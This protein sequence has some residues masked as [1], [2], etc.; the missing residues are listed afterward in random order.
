MSDLSRTYLELITSYHLVK[1]CDTFL[2]NSGKFDPIDYYIIKSL[3][4]GKF[5]FK[6]CLNRSCFFKLIAHV[7]FAFNLYL[8]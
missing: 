8:Y 4:Q 6:N 3:V 1:A 7:L 5:Y 2:N